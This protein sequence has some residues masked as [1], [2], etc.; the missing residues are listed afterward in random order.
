MMTWFA[1]LEKALTGVVR[2]KQGAR[3]KKSARTEVG[4]GTAVR[5]MTEAD[6]T[7]VGELMQSVAVTIGKKT[8]QRLDTIE[9]RAQ[10]AEETATNAV[11]KALEVEEA[12]ELAKERSE[13]LAARVA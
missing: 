1:D 2:E 3:E 9:A 8:A 6:D 4:K 12:A 13:G 7:W 5:A 11:A 10:K